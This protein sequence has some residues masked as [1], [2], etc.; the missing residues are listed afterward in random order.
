MKNR[1]LRALLL[2]AALGGLVIGATPA[3]AAT[4][5]WDDPKG[6]GKLAGSG[7]NDPAF[8]ITNVTITNDG[9][10]LKWDVAVPGVVAGRPTVSTGYTFRFLFTQGEVNFRIQVSENLL[11]EKSTSLSVAGGTLP[12]P[13]L[14][15]EK[16]EGKIDREAKK[17]VFT[18][19]LASIDKAVQSAK[20]P[21]LAGQEWTSLSVIAH[22][23]VGVPNPGGALPASG[24]VFT[25]DT[26]AAPEGTALAF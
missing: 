20:A 19:P 9:G 21:P 16:C 6:D 10:T 23:P 1:V 11:G 17:V 25:D 5:T 18:A 14:A 4:V 26:A 2:G 22:R 24:V 3:Q 7:S 15:C 12:A 8:D 13:P